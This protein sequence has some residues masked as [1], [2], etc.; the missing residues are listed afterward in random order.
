MCKLLYLRISTRELLY[1]FVYSDIDECTDGTND[2]DA[3]AACTNQ[4]GSFTC[5]CN[6]GY[7]GN[8]NTCAGTHISELCISLN[9]L[10]YTC[11]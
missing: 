8:G 9:C 11:H 6:T 4:D 7:T 10:I 3:N 1:E 5:V 2:C